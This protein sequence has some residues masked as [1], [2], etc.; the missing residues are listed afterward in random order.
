MIRLKKSVAK[1]QHSRVWARSCH[2]KVQVKNRTVINSSAE[3]GRFRPPISW[4]NGV[5]NGDAVERGK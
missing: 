5:G 3:S 2:D 1:I 4:R